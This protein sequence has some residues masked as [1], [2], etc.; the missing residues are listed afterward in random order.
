MERI[1]IYIQIKYGAGLC[2]GDNEFP[3]TL[4]TQNWRTRG[5]RFAM[6]L[7]TKLGFD[8]GIYVYI[9]EKGEREK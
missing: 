5:E 4:R 6:F 2:R 1:L 9:G 3:I 8:C 7:A